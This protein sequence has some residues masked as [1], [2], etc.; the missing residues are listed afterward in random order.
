MTTFA[1]NRTLVLSAALVA[2]ASV[3]VETWAQVPPPP[4]EVLSDAYRGKAYSPYAGRGFPSR[5]YWGDTHLHTAIS[6]DAGLSGTDLIGTKPIVSPAATRS[7]R[8]VVS[9]QDS[10]EPWTGYWLLVTGE[11]NR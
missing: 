8:P 6:M 2:L 4:P 7:R 11:Q 5:V 3:T 1:S 10:R 9:R